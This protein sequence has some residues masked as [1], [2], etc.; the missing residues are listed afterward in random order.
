MDCNT[1]EQNNVR[2]PLSNGAEALVSAASF[3]LHLALGFSGRLSADSDGR[4]HTYPRHMAHDPRPTAG[5]SRCQTLART[6]VAQRLVKQEMEGGDSAPAKGWVVRHAN[7]DTLDCRDGNLLCVP[8]N[9]LRNGIRAVWG[10][11]ERWKLMRQGL[12]PNSVFAHRRR[13]ARSKYFGSRSE[14]HTRA[15]R[16]GDPPCPTSNLKR[17]RDRPGVGGRLR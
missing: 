13:V 4:G 9:G 16:R 15:C 12:N 7:G 8:C 3:D 10:V 17:D 6:L 2:V 1:I 14:T 5:R 11:R